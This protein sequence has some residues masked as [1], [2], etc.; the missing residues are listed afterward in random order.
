MFWLGGGG[1]AFDGP[2][3]PP[4]NPAISHTTSLVVPSGLV[5]VA[6]PPGFGEMIWSGP[7]RM[8]LLEVVWVPSAL[9]VVRKISPVPLSLVM[10][11]STSA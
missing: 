11:S 9:V 5:T 4:K 1:L 10:I 2:P 6:V 7:H 3:G 8:V